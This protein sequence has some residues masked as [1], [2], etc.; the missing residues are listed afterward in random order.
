M[1]PQ[2]IVT[3]TVGNAGENHEAMVQVDDIISTAKTMVLTM[4]HLMAAGCVSS[5]SIGVD[6]VFLIERAD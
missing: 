3:K 4:G 2:Q 1:R 5:V 6:A